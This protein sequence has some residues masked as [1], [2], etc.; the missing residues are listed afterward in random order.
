MFYNRGTYAPMFVINLI[1]NFV[2]PF[3]FLMTRDAKRKSVWLKVACV[4][5]IIGHWF[6][7]YLMVA[8]GTIQEHGGLN[9]GTLFV[10]LGIALIYVGLFGYV[11]LMNLSKLPLIPKNHPML[12][13]SI[14]FH[15]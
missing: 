9:L 4:A 7:T 10:E 6:D 11:V 5:I 3:F 1:I 14:H 2:F 15:Q 13:E 8:P 12:E